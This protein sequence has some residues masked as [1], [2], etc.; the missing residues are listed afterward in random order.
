MRVRS[1]ALKAEPE[2]RFERL[3][4]ELVAGRVS[5]C[6]VG[7]FALA[8]HGAP[9]A[10]AHVD[11]VPETSLENLT[12]LSNV[13]RQLG[14]SFG[15]GDPAAALSAA[16]LGG[17]EIKL[18]TDF[19]QLHV[20]GDA[21]TVPSYAELSR[22]S[23]AIE[24]AGELVMFCSRDDLVAMKKRSGRLIDRADLERLEDVEER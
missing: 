23:V 24:V 6:V 11:I 18:Y 9:R 21:E 19:G 17:P 12:R 2:S 14:A 22:N 7:S 8:V 15:P 20:L 16:D 4:A 13:L 1:C 3:L 10:S 5:F